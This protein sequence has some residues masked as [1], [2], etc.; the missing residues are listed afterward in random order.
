MGSLLTLLTIGGAVS[1]GPTLDCSSQQC[2]AGVFI[3]EIEHFNQKDKLYGFRRYGFGYGSMQVGNGFGVDLI[4]SSGM[5]ITKEEFPIQVGVD[6]GG[7]V[8][9]NSNSSVDSFYR[10]LP[11]I[12][13][14]PSYTL[15]GY[16]GFSGFKAGV[17]AGNYRT[18]TL[19]PSFAVYYGA[20]TYLYSDA[21][22]L[23]ME[24]L[25]SLGGL[26]SV[27]LSFTYGIQTKISIY[28]IIQNNNVQGIIA[29]Q[30]GL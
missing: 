9:F 1:I 30:P 12:T 18:P 20:G 5:F 4:S 19:V 11:G 2:F 10:W 25:R 17:E 8:D 27:S 3:G 7:R 26:E 16:K 21:S 15:F 28:G 29:I 14:G 13:V 23:G 22:V 6:I 24:Y